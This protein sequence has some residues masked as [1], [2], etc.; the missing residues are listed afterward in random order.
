[1]ICKICKRDLPR[2]AFYNSILNRNQHICKK[3]HNKKTQEGREK[4]YN[5]MK[6]L[7]EKDF[8]RYFGGYTISILNFAQEGEYKFLI[9]DTTGETL[10]TSNKELFLQNLKKVVDKL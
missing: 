1:M 9:K 4:Y 3:C 2:D 7:H 5:S 6:K 8:N 10:L